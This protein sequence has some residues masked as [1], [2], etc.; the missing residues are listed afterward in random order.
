MRFSDVTVVA[1]EAARGT[2]G[3]G[4]GKRLHVSAVCVEDVFV[5]NNENHV[6]DLTVR[7]EKFARRFERDMRGFLNWITV[8]AATDRRKGY[9]FDFTLHRKLQ[10]IA[11]AICQRPRFVVFPATPDRSDC[12]NHEASGQTIST[13][14]FSFTGTTT[15]QRTAFG[16]QFRACGMVNRAIDA[17][18]A[19]E[20]C[21]RRVHD[22]INIEF[23]DVAADDLDSAV[24]IL[25][26]SMY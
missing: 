6:P 8:S 9:R 26:R 20:R 13:R 24:G 12:V 21:I 25:H 11:V 19:E 14:D 18:T 2:H 15:A 3:P 4:I 5:P 1:S 16:E 7:G 10:R 17:A 22:R 23:S